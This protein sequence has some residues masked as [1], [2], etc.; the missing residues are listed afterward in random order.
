[1]QPERDRGAQKVAL[2]RDTLAARRAIWGPA[3]E[4]TDLEQLRTT[5][6]LDLVPPAGRV[7]AYLSYRDEPATGLL[8]AVLA[9]RLLLPRL[10]ARTGLELVPEDGS[11]V[12]GPRGTLAPAGRAW[13]GPVALVVAPALLVD[14][15]GARLGRGGG[16]YDRLLARLPGVPVVA[17]LAG[18]AEVVAA[19]PVEAWDVPV[20]WVGLPTGLLRVGSAGT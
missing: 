12:A 19:L 1:M 6:L 16:S 7:A 10:G 8:R 18:P 5:A 13:R 15:A 4:P 3:G 17:L 2:R 14:A 9:G 20:G 11:R